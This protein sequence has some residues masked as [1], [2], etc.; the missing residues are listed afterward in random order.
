M[1]PSACTRFL[2]FGGFGFGR[3]DGGGLGFRGAISLERPG[4]E[5]VEGVLG[6][7]GVHGGEAPLTIFRWSGAFSGSREPCTSVK[8]RD[9]EHRGRTE[10]ADA[11]FQAAA[12]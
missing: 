11:A 5:Q 9:C 7:I 12:V 4:L 10:R 8:Q 3:D 2:G 1:V 6:C